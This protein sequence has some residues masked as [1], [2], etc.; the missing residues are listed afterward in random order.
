[1]PLGQLCTSR[2]NKSDSVAVYP[3][4]RTKGD[5]EP[6]EMSTLVRDRLRWGVE[7]KHSMEKRNSLLRIS[8]LKRVRNGLNPNHLFD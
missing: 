2:A 4:P 5:M 6:T 7:E 8:I 3:K 1:M